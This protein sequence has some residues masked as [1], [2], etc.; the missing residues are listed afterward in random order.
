MNGKMFEGTWFNG[1]QHGNGMIY[2][3]NEVVVK[4]IWRYGKII[5]KLFEKDKGIGDNYSIYTGNTGGV[6]ISLEINNLNKKITDNNNNEKTKKV[7][8]NKE[9]KEE[10]KENKEK[11]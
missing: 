7:E 6:P 1:K 4:G 2:Q 10:F 8:D 3:N 5:K 11:Y 9:S